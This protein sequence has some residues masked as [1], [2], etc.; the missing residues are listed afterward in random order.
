MPETEIS[1]TMAQRKGKNSKFLHRSAIDYRCTNKITQLKDE[2]GT[3]L[4]THQ[5]ISSLLTNHFSQI[6]MEPNTN[7]EEAIGEV[8]ISIC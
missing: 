7:R 8:M 4:Q 5:E 6:A 1:H 3:P 2:Q